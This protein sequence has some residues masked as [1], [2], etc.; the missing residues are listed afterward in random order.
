M[1]QKYISLQ[2]EVCLNSDGLHQ[3]YIP[4]ITFNTAFLN[5]LV[6]RKGINIHWIIEEKAKEFQKM[7][8]ILLHCAKVFDYVWIHNKLCKI[9]R[10]ENTR[11]LTCLLNYTCTYQS[12]ATD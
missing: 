12:E 1:A 5:Q 9:L 11:P 10:N 2:P 6:H 3:F 7:H 8:P 4:L